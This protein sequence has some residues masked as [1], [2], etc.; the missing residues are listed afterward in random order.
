[1]SLTL[2]D[3]LMLIGTSVSLTGCWMLSPSVGLIGTGLATC[4]AARV[5]HAITTQGRKPR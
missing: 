4:A 5:V 2:Q 1:M 3:V